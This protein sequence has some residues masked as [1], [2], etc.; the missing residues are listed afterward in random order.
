M[1]GR[2]DLDE[3]Q[4][5][6]G[7]KREQSSLLGRLICR[8]WIASRTWRCEGVYSTMMERERWV[9]VDKEVKYHILIEVRKCI[10]WQVKDLAGLE[11][12]RGQGLNELDA[13]VSDLSY[14]D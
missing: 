5:I 3:H 14:G 4:C 9:Q 10:R 7:M 1:Q 6:E 11:T 2:R 12:R 13:R 8:R